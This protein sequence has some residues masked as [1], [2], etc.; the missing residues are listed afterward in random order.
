MN[1]VE[2]QEIQIQ[3]PLKLKPSQ[4]GAAKKPEACNSSRVRMVLLI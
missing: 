4:Y 2:I 1:K 3:V